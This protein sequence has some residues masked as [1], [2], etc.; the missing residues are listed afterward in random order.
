LQKK[1]ALSNLTPLTLES[2]ELHQYQLILIS[3]DSVQKELQFFFLETVKFEITNFLLRQNSMVDSMPH[4]QWLEL[5]LET[6]L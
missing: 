6:L 4:L 2:L 1:L 5:V 3:M